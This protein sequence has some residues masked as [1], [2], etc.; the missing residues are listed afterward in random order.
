MPEKTEDED[1]AME[2]RR[3][4]E[5]RLREKRTEFESMK[6]KIVK[7]HVQRPVNFVKQTLE[8]FIDYWDQEML[9]R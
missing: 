9:K 6:V 7:W 3:E 8:N 2:S 4:K 5:M 1:E